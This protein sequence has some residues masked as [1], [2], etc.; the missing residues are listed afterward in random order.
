[1]NANEL[2]TILRDECIDHED[3]SGCTFCSQEDCVRKCKIMNL[4]GGLNPLNVKF[5]GDYPEE[6]R[7]KRQMPT[8]NIKN[9][10]ICK[11]E[12]DN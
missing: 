6:K 2:L 7:I 9:V 5:S 10:Y 1:M 11:R 8:I 3:C 12:N 4:T